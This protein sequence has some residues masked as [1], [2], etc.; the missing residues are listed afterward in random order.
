M[1]NKNNTI[2]FSVPCGFNTQLRKIQ[3]IMELN[4]AIK[5]ANE[6]IDVCYKHK[7]YKK[8]Q[9][10]KKITLQVT[11]GEDCLSL[12]PMF[13]LREDVKMWKQRASLFIEPLSSTSAPIIDKFYGVKR[14][15][16]NRSIEAEDTNKQDF[17]LDA[18]KSFYGRMDL[19]FYM[20]NFLDEISMSD[21]N[22]FFVVTFDSFTPPQRPTI[23]PLIFGC[24][25]VYDF[26]YKP[27][28]D[29]DFLFLAVDVD[30][31][32]KTTRNDK[33]TDYYVL[34]EGNTIIY[35]EIHPDRILPASQ[36]TF[37]SANNKNYQLYVL[38]NG[39]SKLMN[40]ETPARRLGYIVNK[41]NRR[42]CDTPIR[43]MIP[44]LKD[45][46]RDKSELDL[47]KRCHVF[48]QKIMYDDP[49]V[50]EVHIDPSRKCSS[51]KITGTDETCT[52]C[53]GD[54][55]KVHRSGQEVIKLRKPRTK[56]EFFPLEDMV[57]YL[58]N[59]LKAVEFLSSEIDKNTALCE[60]AIFS[61]SVTNRS[62]FSSSKET[63]TATQAIISTEEYNNVLD[64]WAKNRAEWFMFAVR[65]IGQVFDTEVEVS[66]S[67]NGKYV[68]EN[69]SQMIDKLK[70]LVDAGVSEQIID[71]AEYRLAKTIFDNDKD[72]LSRYMSKRLFLPFRGRSKDEILVLLES[73][74]V[75]KRSKVL[76]SNFV[77]IFEE[78]EMDLGIEFYDLTPQEQRIIILAK[79]DGIIS[80]L[81]QEAPNDL[82][83]LPIQRIPPQKP[84]NDPN[85][86]PNNP[87]DQ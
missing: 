36:S 40:N 33:L 76:Y 9:E 5:R 41:K 65:I 39:S 45:I 32:K 69:E 81:N 3:F 58:T 6:N 49:C 48:P 82:L 74:N 68:M 25:Q 2:F 78:I 1:I 24:E 15:K 86:D 70:T 26:I 28:G 12:I 17:I 87:N 67:Y 62:N 83:G 35:K 11:T 13:E 55:F 23:Y 84:I 18:E 64:G 21:P 59:D 85:T 80:T 54:G 72:A 10:I 14:I 79:V 34:S 19:D 47:S 66:Y 53:G 43:P 50:G 73:V 30:V 20:D 57:R 7:D 56:D 63:N 71:E 37:Q 52:T 27:N 22:A 60:R 4:E 42:I 77:E 51:G 44:I 8:T 29:L 31:R 46:A 61:S 16:A 75:T 38:N